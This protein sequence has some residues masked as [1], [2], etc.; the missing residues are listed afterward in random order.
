MI[1]FVFLIV[2]D[3]LDCFCLSSDVVRLPGTDHAPSP[4]GSGDVT[5][6]AV[7]CTDQIWPQPTLNF[8]VAQS[9]RQFKY[10]FFFLKHGLIN[11]FC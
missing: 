10:F 2:K 11:N 1:A 9:S 7:F 8:T 6:R 3:S 4:G 5:Q